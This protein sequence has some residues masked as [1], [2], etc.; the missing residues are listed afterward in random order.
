MKNFKREIKRMFKAWDEFVLQ[1]EM[2]RYLDVLYNEPFRKEE[3]FDAFVKFLNF[4][5]GIAH[6]PNDLFPKSR[7][8][9]VN[10][11]RFTFASD[12]THPCDLCLSFRNNSGKN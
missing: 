9:L 5:H 7:M 2:Q 3:R 1:D 8:S 12:N 6:L 11:M 10:N 4:H